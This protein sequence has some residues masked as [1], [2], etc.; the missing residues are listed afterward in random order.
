[1]HPFSFLAPERVGPR[2]STHRAAPGTQAVPRL[3][4]GSVS[5]QQQRVWREVR[6][7]AAD[8]CLGG[9]GPTAPHGGSLGWGAD[10]ASQPLQAAPPGGGSGYRASLHQ[11]SM[12][13]GGLGQ[14]TSHCCHLEAGVPGG[15]PTR[16]TQLVSESWSLSRGGGD[17]NA[18]SGPLASAIPGG[19]DS[20]RRLEFA[21]PVGGAVGGGGGILT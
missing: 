8:L 11:L 12:P 14:P 5:F 13:Q 19:R 10:T 4:C 3:L 9:H 6:V 15:P 20:W 16:Q 17:G 2:S 1:M 21:R 18:A 7:S